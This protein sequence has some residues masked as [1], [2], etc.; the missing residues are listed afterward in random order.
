MTKE[1]QLRLIEDVQHA[2][3]AQAQ[4]SEASA[5]LPPERRQLLQ[6]AVEAGK[7]AQAVLLEE[8]RALVHSLAMKSQQPGVPLS[9]LLQQGTAGLLHA[10]ENF[11]PQKGFRFSNYARW[12][13]RQA[14]ADQILNL[15]RR[16][17]GE[18]T[19]V[20]SQY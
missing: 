5:G 2:R 15:L 10:I 13:V 19:L 9:R 3:L 11:D 14:L 8:H 6:D 12:W 16:R 1:E 7:R 4:L 20:I 18:F 17:F